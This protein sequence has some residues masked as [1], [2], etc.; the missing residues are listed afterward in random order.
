METNNLADD[1]QRDEID[2]F[3]HIQDQG[4]DEDLDAGGQTGPQSVNPLAH[5]ECVMEGDEEGQEDEED[6]ETPKDASDRQE[7]NETNGMEEDN[8]SESGT[9]SSK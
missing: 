1:D 5:V 3:K 2:I 7:A 9:A 6:E 8:H 4:Q